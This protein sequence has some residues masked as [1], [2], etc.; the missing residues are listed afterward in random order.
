MLVVGPIERTVGEP[1]SFS[2]RYPHL[3]VY[4][5]G[6]ECGIGAVVP[7]AGRLWLITYTQHSP[8]GS[9]DKLYEIDADLQMTVRPES[10]GGTPASRMIH[11]ESNQLFIGPYAI[12]AER[13]VRAIPYDVMYGRHTATARHV[14]D[15]VNKVLYLDMEGLIYEVDVKTLDVNMLFRRAVPG[16]HAKGA[17]TSQGQ[18]V[19]ANNG[20]QGAG[21][22]KRFEPFEYQIDPARTGPEDAGALA[23]WDG[24]RWSLIRRRQFTEVTGPGGIYGPRR[25]TARSGRWAG[26]NGL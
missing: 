17:Y 24:S 1:I 25:T 6:G 22:A 16:W 10:I 12:D 18:F 15:P 14:T 19:V 21:S 7:W 5:S 9:D 13:N 11:R 20:E 23:E 26:T 8:G 4:N 2:G 3:A